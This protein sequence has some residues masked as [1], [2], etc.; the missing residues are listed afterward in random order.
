MSGIAADDLHWR[1]KRGPEILGA[2]VGLGFYRLCCVSAPKHRFSPLGIFPE[3]EYDSDS[4]CSEERFSQPAP[5]HFDRAEHRFF[6]PLA[7]AYDGYL[8]EFL[9]AERD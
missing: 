5:Q 8:E 3:F 2:V 4:L 1:C 7:Y 9:S 6:S